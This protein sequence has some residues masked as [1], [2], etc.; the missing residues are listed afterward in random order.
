MRIADD[1]DAPRTEFVRTALGSSGDLARSLGER[2]KL[3]Y[4][5]FSTDVDRVRGV[6]ELSYSGTTTHLSNAIDQVRQEMAGVPLA[7]V[8]PAG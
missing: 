1:A 5:R 2:F 6:D 8:G 4:F 7:G 3:R